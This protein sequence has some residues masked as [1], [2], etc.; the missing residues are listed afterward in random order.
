MDIDKI[1]WP[2]DYRESSTAATWWKSKDVED[3]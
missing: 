1:E 2:A 3:Y